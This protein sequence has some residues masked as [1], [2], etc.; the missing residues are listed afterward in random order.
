MQIG[1]KLHSTDV[2]QSFKHFVL[3]HQQTTRQTD[4]DANITRIIVDFDN[5]V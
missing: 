4:D 3:L 2:T 1:E 5:A